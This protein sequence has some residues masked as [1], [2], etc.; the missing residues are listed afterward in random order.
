MHYPSPP[1]IGLLPFII[2]GQ[3][4]QF[5]AIARVRR[6]QQ[7]EPKYECVVAIHHQWSY[8]VF[9]LRAVHRFVKLLENP[10]NRS[11]VLAEL[12]LLEGKAAPQNVRWDAPKADLTQC[13]YTTFLFADAIYT[14]LGN[15]N[16]RAFSRLPWTHHLLSCTMGSMDGGKPFSRSF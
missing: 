1:A 7:S 10:T 12:R 2:M 5:F 6:P 4:H 11:I 3:R 8:G 15:P 9:P 16:D 14:K 13:H